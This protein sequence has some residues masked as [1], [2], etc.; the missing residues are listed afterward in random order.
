MVYRSFFKK[1]KKLEKITLS[2]ISLESL[3]YFNLFIF[4]KNTYFYQVV[5]LLIISLFFI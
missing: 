4:N 2:Y 1:F 3:N 5:F